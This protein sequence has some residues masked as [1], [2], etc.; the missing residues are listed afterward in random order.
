MCDTKSAAAALAAI[1]SAEINTEKL[2]EATR[3]VTA[4]WQGVTLAIETAADAFGKWLKSV[5]AEVEAQHE[6]ETALR[7]ASVDNRRL[8]DRYRHTKKSRI[9]KKYEKRILAWYRI[10]VANGN[11]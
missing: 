1:P 2:A 8:Y 3:V 4:A 11:I 6:I 5:A 10:E 9:R 7:W